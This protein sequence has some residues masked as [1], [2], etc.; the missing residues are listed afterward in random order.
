MPKPAPTPLE[1]LL[2]DR[3]S[4]WLLLL[5]L[6][7]ALFYWAFTVLEEKSLKDLSVPVEFTGVPQNMVVTGEDARRLVTLE[8]KGPP[9]MLRR[10]REEDVDVKVDVSKLEPGPQ[11]VD[12][13]RENVRLPSSVEFARTFPRTLHFTLD[14]RVRATL[15]LH[16]NFTGKCPPGLAVLGWSIDPP[17]TTVDGPETL[18]KKFRQVPTQPVALDGRA[19]DF[20]VPVVPNLNEPDVAVSSTS[21]FTLKVTVGEARAQRAIGPIQIRVL[22]A[23]APVVLTP[24]SLKVMVDGPASIVR[25]LSPQDLVAEVDLAGLKPADKEVQLRPAVRFVN[26]SIGS[27]VEITSLTERFVGVRIG[28][29]EPPE[30]ARPPGAPSSPQV[31]AP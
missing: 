4:V 28:A 25:L 7:L 6:V 5:A 24:P 16:P 10:V 23:P 22:H 20:A 13:G 17:T 3:Q 30:A 1:R 21:S 12:L 29:Q 31:L 2:P 14:R 8:V 19:Q 9:D 27:R 18:V 26:A 11:V 15:P